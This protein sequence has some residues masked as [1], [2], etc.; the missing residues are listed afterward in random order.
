M[1][2]RVARLNEEELR[3]LAAER[4][5]V[6]V[7]TETHDRVY[8][9]WDSARLRRTVD[10]LC[11]LTLRYSDTDDASCL[12]GRVVAEDADVAEFSNTHARMFEKLTTPDFV[13]D[14]RA[15]KAMYTLI[16]TYDRMRQGVISEEDAR[17]HAAG[18]AIRHALETDSSSDATNGSLPASAADATESRVEEVSE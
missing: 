15:L 2:Y 12:R 1:N 10:K 4:D 13:R 17:T 18:V 5:D 7:Y 16:A 8:E 3:K 11:E 14:P 6:V 9:P